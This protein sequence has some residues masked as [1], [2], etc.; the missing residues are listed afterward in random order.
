MASENEKRETVAD[1]VAVMRH[2]AELCHDIWL[3]DPNDNSQS[4]S[5][6]EILNGY[7]RLIE[8]AWKRERE[9]LE[10]YAASKMLDGATIVD[11]RGNAAA[12]REALAEARKVIK[13]MGGYWARITL[14]IIDAALSAPA[15]NCDKMPDIDNLTMHDLAKSPCKSTLEYASREELLALVRWLLAPAAE[16]KGEGDGR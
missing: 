13:A 12:L 2:A 4:D 6:C 15:R 16:R 8:A 11:N 14:P 7:A 10:R 3:N 5:I 9:D 1:I